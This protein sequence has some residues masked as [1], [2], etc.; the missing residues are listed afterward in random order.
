MIAIACAAESAGLQARTNSRTVSPSWSVYHSC[1]SET[2]LNI[3]GSLTSE[4]S[5]G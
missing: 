5:I 1:L 3:L 2:I 4:L